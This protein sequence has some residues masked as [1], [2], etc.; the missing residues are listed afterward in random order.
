MG[1]LLQKTPTQA[2]VSTLT[3]EYRKA[4]ALC[5]EAENLI[6]YLFRLAGQTGL[7]LKAYRPYTEAQITNCASLSGL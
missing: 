7:C 3:K 4:T 5:A 1:L 2:F 6:P